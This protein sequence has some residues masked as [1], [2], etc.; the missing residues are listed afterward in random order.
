MPSSLRRKTLLII[1][2]TMLGLV[3]GLFVLSR[4]VL[5]RGFAILEEDFAG[6]DIA[7]ASSALANELSTLDQTTSE[8]ATWDLTYEY[9]RGQRPSYI[10]T[11]FPAPTFQELKISFVVI[12]DA[13]GRKLFAKGFDL[14]H[15]GEM[16]VPAGL[17]D[18]LKP[19]SLLLNLEDAH[20]K[21]AGVLDL[22][23][24]PALVESRPILASDASGPSAGTMIMG[25]LLD[26]AEIQHLGDLTL[27]PVEAQTLSSATLSPDFRA[28]AAAISR[29]APN[30]ISPLDSQSLA[31]YQE[32]PDIYGRPAL[33]IRVLLPRTIYQQGQT[34]LVQ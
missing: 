7:R 5:M 29:G 16:P 24:G 25:H 22:P 23:G 3:G 13:H 2:I 15:G 34:S 1:G 21:V 20:S 33:L 10:K 19:G 32:L 27:M 17:D 12:F 31:A 9:A 6:R 11:E 8:Y 26:A 28:A 14:T 18:H 30:F 4:I